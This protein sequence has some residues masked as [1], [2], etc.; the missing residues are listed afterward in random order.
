MNSKLT[1]FF[2]CCC[3]L[4]GANLFAQQDFTQVALDH[5]R[6][7]KA[8]YEL[9]D[10]DLAD[11]I[12]TDNYASRGSGINHIFFQQR[13]Q[14]I[15]L[16][17]A[18]A[19]ANISK[20]GKLINMNI[21]LVDHV[22][23]KITNDAV[24][25]TAEDAVRVLT[26]KVELPFPSLEILERKS[27]PEKFVRFQKGNF[28]LEPVRAQLV[29]QST[30]EEELRLCWEVSFYEQVGTHHWI[31]RI[32]AQ[33]G[34]IWHAE[35]AV[36]HC[37]FGTPAHA[38]D[39]L[40]CTTAN[41]KHNHASAT[42]TTTTEA[43]AL[44]AGSYRVFALPVESP[45][46]GDRSLVADPANLTASP[47]GWHDTGVT[48]YTITRGN[49]VHAYQDSEDNNASIGDEPDGGATL[50][51]D[52]PYAQ[53]TFP[54]TYRDAS[55][56]NLFYWTNLMHDIWYVY[57]FDEE[58]GNFQE[59][60]PNGLG[61]EGDYIRAEAQ[62]GSGTNNA[63]FS[64]QGDGSS[65]RIQM[66]LWEDGSNA[67]ELL[68]VNSPS[69]IA[70]GY[71]AVEGSFGAPLSPTTPIE[72]ELVLAE[73]ISGLA[74]QACDTLGNA[75]EMNQKIAILD[76][77]GCS[78]VV[79][80][81]NAQDAGA[82]AAI[83]CNNDGGGIFSPGGNDND[84]VIPCV[85]VSQA[86][87][88]LIKTELG[89][90]VTVSLQSGGENAS[91]LDGDFDNGIVCHEYGHG[92][93]GR[94]TG[95]PNSP[96]CLNNAEQMGEGWSDW[97]GMILTIEPGDVGS[98]IRGMGTFAAAQSI[99]GN[100]IRPAPYST[101]FDINN[102]TYGNSNDGNISQPHGV[103][104]I[105]ATAI[106]DLTWALIDQ[107][108]Y[109]ADL[110]TGT[111]GNNIAMTL[112]MEGI[113][114]QPCNPGMIDGR[115]AILLADQEI[116]NGANQC[117]IWEVF[118]RRGF[119]A[120][121]SQGSA[122]N[123]FDQVEAFDLPLI[124]QTPVV[125]PNA[126]F[127]VDFMENC[128]GDFNFTD[129]SVDVP[130]SWDWTFGDGGTS[131]EQNPTH[132]YEASGTYTVTLVVSNVFG[133][134]AESTMQVTVNYADSPTAAAVSVCEGEP[135]TITASGDGQ[136]NWYLNDA[137]VFSGDT[138]TTPP[139]DANAVLQIESEILGMESNGGPAT[140]AIGP[141]GYHNT[142]FTGA[143]IFEAFAPFVIATVDV[144][145]GSTGDRVIELFD[146]NGVTIDQVTV[147]AE[148]GP[149][150]ITLNMK[151]PEA[152]IYSI[153][154]TSIDLFRNTEGA[155]YPYEIPGFANITSSTATTAA[156]EYYYYLYNWTVREASCLSPKVDVA[157][158]VIDGP[159]A[160]FTFAQVDQN[161][162]F[163]DNST[164]ATSWSWNF[165]DGTT[166]TSENPSHTYEELGTYTVQLEVSNGTCTNIIE[167]V[168]DIL[169][170][171]AEE[172]EGLEAFELMPTIG[173]GNIHLY[174]KTENAQT[175][176]VDVFN[177]IGQEIN[178]LPARRTDVVEEDLSL[179]NLAAGTYI[180]R[181]NIGEESVYK[182]Y[183]LLN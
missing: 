112:V 46:H 48:S 104:F 179:T 133:S 91:D 9:T 81:K 136:I 119:G 25:L 74:A 60:N 111:G 167:Q 149:S 51:F 55:V 20:T 142:G 156:Q 62:D 17:P 72:G 52:Y 21:R 118:A 140:T 45:N 70:G 2:L 109:D 89:T 175:I 63:N 23:Q 1:L 101:S 28:A 106:W 134:S 169:V 100:G 131:T 58:S 144:D 132:I 177:T 148:Q 85:M 36:I 16:I 19:N 43:N 73:A 93:S 154:G 172:I 61:T 164:N 39:K 166:S 125:A 158:T 116:Y 178:L 113:K 123:R 10:A 183:V 138:Y 117:L 41:H 4:S 67:S 35:D 122:F 12:V 141:G 6:T 71:G 115:D 27:G 15:K 157:A 65:A 128:T 38:E 32:D 163:S 76:R 54:S 127:T 102:Y 56:T 50:N 124:C 42:T 159:T 114:M 176:S 75:M 96:G 77:G 107:D 31:M 44:V 68:T 80:V 90:G 162:D 30:P 86:D 99:T 121:A 78:F 97:F 94:M 137:L 108:G 87:C 13:Y 103:G 153:G 130:Q 84:I 120:S 174:V 173:K 34:A 92:I 66:Y 143:V 49:N 126:N 135:A 165:G 95:G 59:S 79:K 5:L 8:Q 26:A 139:L 3:F 33:T 160:D 37:D 22:A 88:N 152:G 180:I 83:I 82:I 24:S 155:N 29:Y 129:Q 110:Y 171:G 182:K 150:T 47:L 57:G 105:W 11:L 145:A 181:I 53:N 98:K 64:S 151:V 40:V 161:F 7:Q 168:V 18:T 147:F 14:G 170:L 69:N 146:E